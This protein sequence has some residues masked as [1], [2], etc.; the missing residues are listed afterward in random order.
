MLGNL[1]GNAVKYNSPG[2]KVRVEWDAQ[3]RRL[4]VRDSGPG[5]PAEALPRIFERFYRGGVSRAGHEGT[6]LG[7][8]IVKHAAARYGLAVS[9]ESVLGVGSRFLLEAP[10]ELTAAAG[11][12]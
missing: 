8:A 12:P 10:A 7:L 4:G 9:A 11:T 6:G 5:I 1:I 2:G 3:T